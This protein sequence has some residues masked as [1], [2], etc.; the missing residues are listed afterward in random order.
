[1]LIRG[2]T[3]RR[4]VNMGVIAGLCLAVGLLAA[5][6][7]GASTVADSSPHSSQE[8]GLTS[9]SVADRHQAPDLSGTS[10]DGK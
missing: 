8:P 2:A 10:L 6:Q 1:M 4:R 5:C 7:P 3:S 9:Y